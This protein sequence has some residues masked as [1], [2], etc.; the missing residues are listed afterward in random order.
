MD[1]QNAGTPRTGN[2][3]PKGNACLG[4][5]PSQAQ[6]TKQR[7]DHTASAIT[8]HSNSIPAWH[9]CETAAQPDPPDAETIR[10]EVP[11][12]MQQ[13]KCW[14]LWKL[15][16]NKDP[17]KPPRKVPYYCDGTLRRGTLDGPED[18]ARLVTLDVALEALQAAS[19]AYAGPGFALGPDGSGGHWQGIDLDHIDARPELAA[20]VDLLPGYVEMS[21]SG[22]GVHA[23]G[24]GD[25]FVS[26]G[27]NATGIEAYAA[28]RYFTV[29]GNA[30]GGGITDLR[31]FVDG[32]LK[33]LHE[34]R[35]QCVDSPAATETA[36]PATVR[37]LRSALLSMRSDDRSLWI[38]MGHALKTL[39]D[40]GRGLYLE[41]SA[42]SEKFDPADAARTWDSFNPQH[43]DYRAVF[44][45]AQRRGWVN[46]GRRGD[47]D[48]GPWATA[49]ENFQHGP[50]DSGD[51]GDSARESKRKGRAT[52]GRLGA[53]IAGTN[54]SEGP[55][56]GQDAHLDRKAE[57]L[58]R[59]R[60]ALK[61]DAPQVPDYP[62]DALGPL[63]DVARAIADGGQVR[64]AVAAQ[65]VLAVACLLAQGRANVRSLE[66]VKPLSSYFL[67]IAESGDGKTTSDTIA[68]K[69]VQD[70]QRDDAR[71][72]ARDLED[73]EAA[74]KKEKPEMP[75]EP[76]RVARDGTVEGIR[77]SFAMGTPS[78]AV[79]SSEAAAMLSGYG[80]L[81]DNKAKT[82][83]TFNGLF[84]DGEIS[85]ARSGA[86]RIQ[87]YDRRLSIHWLIQPDA[88]Q[89]TLADPLLSNIGFWPRFLVA[90]PA[91]SEPRLARQ[92]RAESDGHIRAFWSRCEAM[93]AGPLR[94]DCSGLPILEP[95][96][97]AMT[98]LGRFFEGMEQAAK[99]PGATLT[100]I[101]PFAVRAAELAVRLAGVLSEFED[102]PTIDV[103]TMRGG[104]VLATRSLDTWQGI[105]GTRDDA[106][107]ASKAMLLFG[108]LLDQAGTAAESTT[109]LH[110]GPKGLRSKDARDAALA[111][112]EQDGL[113][114]RE[115]S[116]WTVEA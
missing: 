38:D 37:D 92:W 19:G 66:A 59:A 40:P 28:G 83:A 36:D 16:P 113:V 71:R 51:W 35:H 50:G 52:G 45:E 2:C 68:Q 27:S 25:R 75:R 4:D 98:L 88:A 109:M 114:Y 47:G 78:Q 15:E 6:K 102:L 42:T 10:T 34:V 95:T 103:Q 91:P 110:V 39:G 80:M 20:L 90:W 86:G 29:T 81:P 24:Y 22:T 53:T 63:A 62:I 43:I 56:E 9:T 73:F 84:D 61:P 11:H 7:G 77:R 32:T 41:W 8:G 54:D 72:F 115:G 100:S 99:G 18:V 107:A 17:S 26:L 111:L 79:F 108:W 112:L 104:I 55:S 5:E 82:A 33:P 44:A 74:P 93:M 1:M 64:P 58:A 57:L 69:A 67:T 46:P 49:S 106:R 105:F 21:P 94:D 87:L 116:K 70:R 23:V 14:L 3:A 30:I 13:A 76:Y 60:R 96:D 89:S 97:E 12:R 85:V 65:S 101:K 31:P 48:P